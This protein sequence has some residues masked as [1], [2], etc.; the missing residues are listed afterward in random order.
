MTPLSR[1]PSQVLR[2]ATRLGGALVDPDIAP[3]VT[4]VLVNGEAR[5]LAVARVRLRDGA[6]LSPAAL[7]GHYAFVFD[8]S[9]LAIG[10]VVEI[11]FRTGSAGRELDGCVA[12][13]V[14]ANSGYGVPSLDPGEGV[15]LPPPGG[16]GEGGGAVVFGG[17]S[18][19][20]YVGNSYT[21]QF[22]IPGA[23]QHYVNARL[24]GGAVSLGPPP[25]LGTTI[26]QGDD[27]YYPAMTL[28]GMA[29][30][31]TIDQRQGPGSTDAI[32]ALASPPPSTYDAVILTS[33]FIQE[34]TGD[35]GIEAETVPGSGSD[36]VVLE[37][38][39][40]VI[41]E[42][43]S[44]LGPVLSVVVRM[45]HEGYL[46]ND[47]VGLAQYESFVRRQV[48]A[49]RQLEA[50]GLALAV[51]PEAYVW[52]RLTAG[53]SGV[54]GN[55]PSDPVPAF[56]GLTHPESTQPGNRNYGW[57]NRTQGVTAPFNWNG[58]QNAIG[59]IV[60]AWTQG[61][62]GWDIDPRGDT[63]FQSPTGL[64]NP[65]DDF[66]SQDGRIYGGHATN[67]GN[68]PWDPAVN[69]GGPP[70]PDLVLDWSLATQA[71]I[72]DRIVAA[73][74]DYTEGTTEFD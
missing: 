29:L 23:T 5:N 27:G 52:W 14:C 1:T 72:Q 57:L 33:G 28:G 24:A 16:G 39:R 58:H 12:G 56:V 49:A 37:V 40:R 47:D 62:I 46:L 35:D 71:Q 32:D 6:P 44:R 18:S 74:D 69:P 42:I 31:P 8:G 10:D 51:I 22:N 70:D 43:A 73:C 60:A 25:H 55:A 4:N 11:L 48:L 63:T 65:L 7:D 54:V 50:E 45:T 38:K 67:V 15:V 34:Q 64:P 19:I 53:A 30:F 2:V 36:T 13:R 61:Y 59:S 20:A 41:S 66:I 68:T 17:T 21:Q 3:T 9:S 26:S